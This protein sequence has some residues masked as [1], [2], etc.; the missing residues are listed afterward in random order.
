MLFSDNQFRDCRFADIARQ[1][2]NHNY[3]CCIPSAVS[4]QAPQRDIPSG[5]NPTGS[6]R[7]SVIRT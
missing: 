3:F 4:Y 5:T 2:L 6:H 1:L 7:G